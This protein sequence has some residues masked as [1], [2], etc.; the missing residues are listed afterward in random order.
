MSL[1]KKNRK[2]YGVFAALIILSVVLDQWTKHLAVLHLK[3]QPSYRLIDGVFH[4]SYVENPGAAFGIL[5]R[6]QW[7]FWLFSIVG[8]LALSVYLFLDRS[9]LD[10]KEEATGQ[11]P[12]I[13]F[14]VGLCLSAIIG[15]GIGN[16]IDRIRL[17]YVVDFFDFTLIDFAVFNVA[18][19]FVTVGSVLLIVLLAIPLFQTKKQEKEP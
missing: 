13:P 14:S 9:F 8:I 16:M 7:V 19:S 17:G 6:H 5:S 2:K 11:Y 12:P 18:D 15:G 10:E 3:G 1:L 4:L